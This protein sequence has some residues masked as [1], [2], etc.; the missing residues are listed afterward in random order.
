M[1]LHQD[2]PVTE[3]VADESGAG[4]NDGRRLSARDRARRAVRGWF[5]PR[6]SVEN[7]QTA[8][9]AKSKSVYAFR[10]RPETRIERPIT[11][12]R[13][14]VTARRRQDQ[15]STGVL[16]SG[17]SGKTVVLAVTVASSLRSA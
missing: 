4:T 6:F 16:K 14:R 7:S 5:G 8:S 12:P 9:F 3:E 17:A 1:A 15:L 13:G 11:A 2:V 10:A